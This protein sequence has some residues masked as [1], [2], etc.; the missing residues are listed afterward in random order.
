MYLNKLFF[1]ALQGYWDW[2]LISYLGFTMYLK[3]RGN[4]IPRLIPVQF[5]FSLIV[6]QSLAGRCTWSQ[7]YLVDLESVR[8]ECSGGQE[9]T[10]KRMQETGQ[11]FRC[12][13]KT[14]VGDLLSRLP[15]SEVFITFKR[16][17][18]CLKNVA[19]CWIFS[20]AT[21]E[22]EMGVNIFGIFLLF[23]KHIENLISVL[24]KNLVLSILLWN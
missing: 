17:L 11:M 9:P 3:T 24:A 12:L 23:G 10:E 2:I 21:F 22:S 4:T 7:H 14:Q 16:G 5:S 13:K 8:Q 6:I 19:W 1:G 15:F 18:R 20:S